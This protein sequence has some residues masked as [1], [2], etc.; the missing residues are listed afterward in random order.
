MTTT[1]IGIIGTGHWGLGLALAFSQ[2]GH[3]VTLWGRSE[4]KIAQLNGH[5]SFQAF[6]P[7]AFP[8]SLI[9]SASA[10]EAMNSEIIISCLPSHVSLQVWSEHFLSFVGNQY[11][12]HST[13]GLLGGEPHVLSQA[14][15]KTTKRPWSFLTGPSFAHEVAQGLPAT[16]LLATPS[17]QGKHA[18]VQSSLSSDTLRVYLS[19]DLLGAE[20]CAAMKNILAIAAGAVD[21]L[22]LG[23]NAKAA[24][25]T[26][27]LN[28][29]ARLVVGLGGKTETVFGLA[30]MGDLFL[31]STG[32]S[33]RNRK[34]GFEIVQKGNLKEAQQ[35]LNGETAEGMFAV[36]HA[37][38]MAKSL[39]IELPI[40]EGVLDL[41]NGISPRDVVSNLFAR[42]IKKESL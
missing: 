31:T 7:K 21:A 13:K 4:T 6:G 20:L 16:M 1:S 15:V 25:M 29:M 26:R 33:S 24:L 11:L 32:T 39:N 14:L 27:G 5:R 35:S 23:Q 42:P 2:K 17:D 38:A 10:S 9:I 37:L 41:M 34:L 8:K 28:E 3:H 30:G 12:I 18:Q 22:A 36:H 19:E 40:T